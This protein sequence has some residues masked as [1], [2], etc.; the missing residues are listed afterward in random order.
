VLQRSTL[1]Y[2]ISKAGRAGAATAAAP[3][4]PPGA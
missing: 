4:T 3:A 1:Q 2:S